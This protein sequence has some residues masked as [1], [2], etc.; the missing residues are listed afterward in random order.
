MTCSLEVNL[1]IEGSVASAQG[2]DGVHT[3]GGG[4]WG[5]P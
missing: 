3:S 2:N 4:V 1:R 5:D